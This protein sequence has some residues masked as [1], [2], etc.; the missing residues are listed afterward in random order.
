MVKQPVVINNQQ[1]EISDLYKYLGLLTDNKFH[2]S[3]HVD[4]QLK[5]ANK[6]VEKSKQEVVFY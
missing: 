6:T 4:Q 2:L 3:S 1:V 5:K